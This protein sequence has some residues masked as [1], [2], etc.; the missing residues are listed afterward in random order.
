VSGESV[1]DAIEHCFEIGWS[2]GLPVVPPYRTL[3]DRMLE[4]LQW[5]GEEVLTSIPG[6]D[7]EVTA[8]QVAAMAVMAGCRPEYGRVLRPLTEAVFDVRMNLAGVE[9]TTGGVAVLVVVSGPVVTELGFDYGGNSVGGANSRPN[10]TIGRFAQMLRY[11]CGS[12]GGAMRANG[13]MGHPGRLSFLIAERPDTHFPP[14]HTQSG[15]PA[16]ASAVSVCSAEGPNSVNNHYS[17][18]AEGILDTIAD[19]LAHAGTTSYYWHHGLYLVVLGPDH[20]ETISRRFSREQVREYLF[21]HA[22]RP[23]DELARLGRIAANPRPESKVVWGALRSP[24]DNPG[25]L[26]VVEGGAPGGRFSAVVPGW[27]GSHEFISRRVADA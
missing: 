6:Q 12:Q 11:F 21:E 19:C 23:T 8:E 18:E 14:F 17:F 3:V 7:T 20:A 24:V 4:A 15:L 26:Y 10:A 13:T 2:D 16:E 9:V 1:V 27:V 22:R 25:L 5:D